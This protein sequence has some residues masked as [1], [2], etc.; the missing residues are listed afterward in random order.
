MMQAIGKELQDA[1]GAFSFSNKMI[2]VLDLCMAPGG[3]AAYSLQ[4]NPMGVVDA[5]SLPEAEGGHPVLVP[6]RDTRV[7]VCFTDITMWAEE[8]GVD[9]IPDNHPD[10]SKFQSAWPY[11]CR[12]YD[13]VICDGQALHAHE[14]AEY[15]KRT[16]QTRLLNSQLVLGLQRI[17]AGGTMIVLLHKPYKWRCVKLLYTFSRFSDIQLFKPRRYHREKS[18]FYLIAKNVQPKSEA[19]IHAI[20]TFRR[21]WCCATFETD[22]SEGENDERDGDD[23]GSILEEFGP[24]FIELA[25]PIWAIQA[26]ALGEARWMGR[27]GTEKNTGLAREAYQNGES[28]DE[29]PA[30]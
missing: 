15:R 23:M 9:H 19:A 7:R 4:E 28:I 22:Q 6:K 14:V 2:Q 10:A 11:R 13:L 21:L 20:N 5:F 26:A 12:A 24:A 8:L 3:F 16:E 27:D 17:K 29:G 18:S 1:T 25:R 30:K